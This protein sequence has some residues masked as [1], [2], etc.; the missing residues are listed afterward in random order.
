[1]SDVL[2]KSILSKQSTIQPS[3]LHLFDSINPATP[4][5]LNILSPKKIVVQPLETNQCLHPSVIESGAE[6]CYGFAATSG[7]SNCGGG[8]M[9]TRGTFKD[10][11]FYWAQF[12]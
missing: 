4:E 5:G 7:P 1:M 11:C 2:N 12:L 10:M 6:Y 8:N 3:N 9:K